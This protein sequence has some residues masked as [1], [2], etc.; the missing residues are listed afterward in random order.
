MLNDNKLCPDPQYLQK[1]V[2]GTLPVPEIEA[3]HEHLSQCDPCVET[4]ESMKVDD[5]FTGIARQALQNHWNESSE[6]QIVVDQ[7]IEQASAWKR[8]AN[9]Q[10]VE[11][12]GSINLDRCA[13]VHRLLAEPEHPEDLGSLAQYRI[14]Q[15]L[16][17]GSTGVVY[18]ALDT[19]LDRPVVLKVLRPSLGEPAR[20]RFIAEGRATA[21]LNH[22][23]I[24]TIYEVGSD[25]PLSYLAMQWLP[26]QTLDEKLQK[27]ETLS[28]PETRKLA[29]QIASGLAAAHEQDLIHRD[30]KP[31]NIW[32]P[33]GESEAKI[34]DF[35]L[36]RIADEDPQLTCT[37]MIAG[38]PCF[39]SP[40]QSRGD[41]IDKRSDLFS[42]GCVLYQCLSGR[43]P[44]RSDNALATLRS[45]QQDQPSELR[46]LDPS[47]DQATSDLVM[48]LLQKAP[49][50]R[51]ESATTV[52]NALQSNPG[53]WT[54]EF[55]PEKAAE[56]KSRKMVGSGIWKAIAAL[57]FCVTIGVSAFAY[58]QQI[59]RVVTN[60]GEIVIETKVDDVKVEILRDSKR[61]QI[62]DLAT[63]QSVVI[64][65]GSYEIRPMNQG[66]SV[67][68]ENGNLVLARGEKEIVRVIHRE[69][70]FDQTVESS[71]S[72]SFPLNDTAPQSIIDLVSRELSDELKLGT[73]LQLDQD[74]MLVTATASPDNA[75]Q[76][77]ATIRRVIDREDGPYRLRRG[78]VLGI[79]IDGLMGN[80]D[81]QPPI[82]FPAN[83]R[84]STGFPITIEHAGTIHIPIVGDVKVSSLT[85][86]EARQKIID[87]CTGGENPVLR[88]NSR[89][90]L[91][92]IRRADH[93]FVSPGETRSLP[94]NR[95]VADNSQASVAY[96]GLNIQTTEKTVAVPGPLEIPVQDPKKPPASNRET[97]IVQPVGPREFKD[98][99]ELLPA[100]A[101]KKSK[102]NV[103]EYETSTAPP[104]T[105]ESLIE[106][107]KQKIT[108]LESSGANELDVLDAKI[109]LQ[110]L[111]AKESESA[112]NRDPEPWRQIIKLRE[113]QLRLIDQKISKTPG[114]NSKS[115]MMS[116]RS[117]VRTDLSRARNRVFIF[118]KESGVRP[119]S[120]PVYEDQIYEHW[121][122]VAK[123]ER[124][125]G[126]LNKAMTGI[127]NLY[128]PEQ[129]QEVIEIALTLGNRGPGIG[130]V[131][132]QDGFK[133][134]IRDIFN[135]LDAETLTKVL[136]REFTQPQRSK[137]TF[138]LDHNYAAILQREIGRNPE[139]HKQTARELVEAL[140]FYVRNFG[141]AKAAFEFLFKLK[142]N[143]SVWN[144][145]EM[146]S[147]KFCVQRYFDEVLKSC[148]RSDRLIHRGNM[149]ASH[150]AAL[151]EYFPA[152]KGLLEL[153]NNDFDYYY[154]RY[155]QIR[156]ATGSSMDSVAW[157]S[158]LNHL[159][160]LPARDKPKGLLELG[161]RLINQDLEL[162][163]KGKNPVKQR[164]NEVL[165]ALGLTA[166]NV[167]K[168]IYKLLG[169]QKPKRRFELGLTNGELELS[170]VK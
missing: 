76:V 140:G 15:L 125:L 161:E 24:V 82:H 79:F 67:K 167:E 112:F 148:T 111:F 93:R 30:I 155:D 70:G 122:N 104:K 124:Q 60:Q 78:D 61:V 45:I 75:D 85:I 28:I 90:M 25:G 165:R 157:L 110:N 63:Q 145:P 80:F 64:A 52:V 65:S 108:E 13:E 131:N 107:A 119:F 11:G 42:L 77:F 150:Y 22:R 127:A 40:E 10:L 117:E 164:R 81:E 163:R 151:V 91:N 7:M 33:D 66:N 51:P 59:V 68:V 21:K 114:A 72:S 132:E 142:K 113:E 153:V 23:N 38:T 4:I 18:L 50:R 101:I 144:F 139:K 96:P 29:G 74:A 83:G 121:Y 54:F 86:A 5:T 129:T 120:Q 156:I 58:G 17:S 44:F 133:L 94:I 135:S 14:Q 57:M 56:T 158:V 87:T 37:G 27:E 136:I 152:T 159:E 98:P 89:I 147:A 160:K 162:Q 100:T 36:V 19:R 95:Q 123:S 1:F 39:M 138:L 168:Q 84:P 102:M 46:E 32:I 3:C 154:D 31:A 71:R 99:I 97:K 49:G 146:P 137:S 118:E 6:D 126:K 20:K 53:S 169:D 34:L 115:E 69:N 16:G 43:L 62:V 109:A 73:N 48:C 9:S 92:L 141:D 149:I 166:S 116:R 105:S 88:D 8:D 26:G 143:W 12:S 106:Q 41:Q 130:D 55:L 47:I 35:G 103:F 2:S 134:I 170:T 128:A